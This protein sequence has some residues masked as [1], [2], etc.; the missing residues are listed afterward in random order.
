MIL[1][2]ILA[3]WVLLPAI[4]ALADPENIN[5]L[6]I[7]STHYEGE[8]SEA[9]NTYSVP[10]LHSWIAK[11]V[12]MP[13]TAVTL[14]PT[15]DDILNN[16]QLL[17]IF[18]QHIKESGPV[19]LLQFF[20]DIGTY[21][22]LTTIHRNIKCFKLMLNN[23]FYLI[24]DDLIKRI[25]NPEMTQDAEKVL[26]ADAQSM[27]DS[28]LDPESPDYVHLP[29]HVSEGMRQSTIFCI[30]QNCVSIFITIICNIILISVLEGGPK[31]IQELRTSRPLYHA[32]E[33]AHALLESTCVSSFHHCYE[34]CNQN[35]STICNQKYSYN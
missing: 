29:L 15:L 21:N 12:P 6:I 35:Y 9:T 33:E 31:K 22:N 16:P 17:Y 20:L 32:H 19:N 5:T 30:L 11:P 26:H 18:M 2:E 14:K 4:D 7:L 10:L 1:R 23:I 34:V 24:S 13:E 25:M 28:Y 27:Y 3:N 8:F